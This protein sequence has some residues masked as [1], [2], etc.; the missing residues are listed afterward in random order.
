M[1]FESFDEK[2]INIELAEEKD[3]KQPS[4]NKFDNLHKKQSLEDKQLANND[5][6]NND[7][8]EKGPNENQEE[9]TIRESKDYNTLDETVCATLVM[10]Y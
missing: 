9:P 10:I 4:N 3:P 1:N 2:N 8:N 7:M 6:N 5:N